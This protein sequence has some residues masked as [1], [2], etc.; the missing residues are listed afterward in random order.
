MNN[1]L[2]QLFSDA[3]EHANNRIKLNQRIEDAYKG[4][5]VRILSD[6]NGQPYGRSRPN[7]KGRIFK[8]DWTCLQPDGR[9]TVSFRDHREPIDATNVEI[10]DEQPTTKEN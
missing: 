6:F 9:I 4:K 5:M 10:I 3:S 7:L 2:R 8:V 1:E